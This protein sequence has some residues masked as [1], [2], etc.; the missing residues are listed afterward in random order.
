[1]GSFTPSF[2]ALFSGFLVE[3]AIAAIQ[4]TQAAAIGAYGDPSPFGALEPILDFHKAQVTAPTYPCCTV[5]ASDSV[6]DIQEQQVMRRY[7]V[8]IIVHLDLSY[9]DPDQLADW[10]YHYARL[11]D[12]IF[13]TATYRLAGTSLWES[14][15]SITWPDKSAPRQTVP[16][17]AGSVKAMVISPAHIGLVPGDEKSAAVQRIS[18]ALD[19][20]MEEH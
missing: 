15:Q 8:S 2:N 1:M 18:I 20:E 13:T 5:V 17:A 10:S 14:E 19:F 3:Q 16:F 12:Q 9:T 7:K 11:L 4:N 6:F